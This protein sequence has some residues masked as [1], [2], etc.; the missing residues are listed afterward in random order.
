M[1]VKRPRVKHERTFEE[2][3]AEEAARFRDLAAQTPAGVKRE[4]YLRRARQ[5]ETASH[6]NEWLKSPGLQPPKRIRE[7]G[8]L[9]TVVTRAARHRPV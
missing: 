8:G 1:I 5:A 2:R 3:L 7:E 6:I 4:V 9:G